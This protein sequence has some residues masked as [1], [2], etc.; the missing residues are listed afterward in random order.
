MMEYENLDLSSMRKAVDDFGYQLRSFDVGLFFYAGHGVQANGEN[1]LIPVDA[2]LKTENDVSYNCVNTGRLLAKMEDA[3]NPTN[4]IILDACRDNPFER[5]WTRSTSSKGLAFMN[6]PAGSL[7]AYA[8]SPGFTA[9][10][11]IGENGLYTSA[12]LH[13]ID[14]TN[15]NILEMFQEVRRYVRTQSNGEQIPWETTSLE[16]NFYFIPSEK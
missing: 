1:Y 13:F 2:N 8:T 9:S 14:R 11:G 12:I 10:D 6:A 4:I 16:G 15:Q 5:S 3:R 7:I